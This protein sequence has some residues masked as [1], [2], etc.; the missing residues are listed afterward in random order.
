MGAKTASFMNGLIPNAR[1]P[2]GKNRLVIRHKAVYFGIYTGMRNFAMKKTMRYALRLGAWVLIMALCARARVADGFAPFAC[3]A[4]AALRIGGAHPLCLLAGCA[5]GCA[6]SGLGF[7]GWQ[8]LIGCAAVEL[9]CRAPVLRR[10]DAFARAIVLAFLGTAFPGLVFSFGIPYNLLGALLSATV[11]AAIAPVLLPIAEWGGK[12]A[13]LSREE[14]F[15]LA[16]L[17]V[18]VAIGL[19]ATPLQGVFTSLCVLAAAM[20]GAGTGALGG[21]LMGAAIAFSGGQPEAAA[22]MGMSGALCGVLDGVPAWGRALAFL[23]V[24]QTAYLGPFGYSLPAAPLP[25][26]ILGALISLALPQS[27]IKA[28]LATGDARQENRAAERAAERLTTLSEALETM[29]QARPRGEAGEGARAAHRLI[30]FLHGA[31][32]QSAQ[33]LSASADLPARPVRLHAS[34]G[35]CARARDMVCGDSYAI[36]PLPGERMLLLLCDGMGT[37]GAAQVQSERTVRL[38]TRLMRAG[39]DALGAIDTANT[40]LMWQ[41]GE[42]FSTL[43]LAVVDLCGGWAELYKLAAPPSLHLRADAVAEISSAGLPIGVLDGSHPRAVRIALRRGD[44][45]FMASDGVM[46]ACPAPEL[47]ALLRAHA[48]ESA[49][50]ACAAVLRAPKHPKDDMT[51]ILVK[52]T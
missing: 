5:L 38:I 29:A 36:V 39:M 8:A 24:C 43:D 10:V 31:L 45:L 26:A 34:V 9:L 27:R 4:Y 6:A 37:G 7:A 44:M 50:S 40:L 32:A 28:L 19:R 30:A 47:S 16:A 17:A 41:D 15:A 35:V 23:A 25:Q 13:A 52:L 51:A 14:Q 46:D 33:A 18:I 49:R 42:T 11:S 48:R 1:Q 3:A 22:V 21:V 2:C 20:G 12:K